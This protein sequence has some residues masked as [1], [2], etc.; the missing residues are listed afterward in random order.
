MTNME[1]LNKEYQNITDNIA[2]YN[3][4]L[5]NNDLKALQEADVALDEAEKE[6]KARKK[7]I[8]YDNFKASASPMLAIITKF[9]YSYI[10][11]Q[12]VKDENGI[13]VERVLN[14][15]P[16]VA[17]H[18]LRAFCRDAGLSTEWWG[19]ICEYNKRL[20][21]VVAQGLNLSKE[22]IKE[23]DRSYKMGWLVEQTKKAESGK[24]APDPRSKTQMAKA[25]QAV[26]D[27]IYFEDDG[28]GKNK[29]RVNN[30]DAFYLSQLFSKQGKKAM[31]VSSA[32]DL[33]L[34]NLV[35]N[36]YHGIVTG[37]A[38]EYEPGCRKVKTKAEPETV[39][40]PVLAISKD[41]LKKLGVSSAEELLE[42]V[43]NG[44][45]AA[46]ETPQEA[47][48]DEGEDEVEDEAPADTPETAEAPA[49]SPE[50]VEAE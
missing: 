41:T 29:Y 46:P 11:H 33:G 32:K 43:K 24:D 39:T 38:Y 42:L 9:T 26:I 19:K 20:A 30:H 17:H 18:D 16:K 31:A 15:T 36:I 5:K 50:A 28:K 14:P 13:V 6:Y 3:E 27:A 12:D 49:A 44:R 2:K 10:G 35:H 25:L 37:E 8:D 48:F 22:R 23:I 47:P 4:A 34:M 1:L 7:K 45:I 40:A 21:L